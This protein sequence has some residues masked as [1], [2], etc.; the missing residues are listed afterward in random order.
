M[1]SFREPWEAQVFA[2]VLALCEAGL[3]SWSEWT[4]ALSREVAAPHSG[5]GG[6]DGYER[7]LATLEGLVIEKDVASA[8]ALKARKDSWARAA[9]ATPHGSPILLANDPEARVR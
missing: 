8:Q 5:E 1:N 4:A 6:A 2:M 3:F 7:W 9:E